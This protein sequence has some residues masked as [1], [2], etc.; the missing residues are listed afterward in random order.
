MQNR[1]V[2]DGI[3][4][5]NE[6]KWNESTS[7]LGNRQALIRFPNGWAA[8]IVIGDHTYGGQDGMYELAV[9]DKTGRIRYD[10]EITDDVIGYLSPS[11]VEEILEQ[12]KN[13]PNEQTINDKKL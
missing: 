3:T 8:S 12:I 13:L 1:I 10:T 5:F 6:L 7:G 11:E 9:L 4:D 2:N